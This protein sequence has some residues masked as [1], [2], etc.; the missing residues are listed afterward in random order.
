MDTGIVIEKE[1]DR[2]NGLSIFF[3]VRVRNR[4]N[5]TNKGKKQWG[6]F[7]SVVFSV[8]LKVRMVA[9]DRAKVSSQAKPSPDLNQETYFPGEGRIIHR[10]RSPE[11]RNERHKAIT[12]SPCHQI[13]GFSLMLPSCSLAVSLIAKMSRPSTVCPIEGI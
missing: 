10:Q 8:Q 2:G 13:W 11:N 9:S 1:G 12:Y 4:D 3:K 5:R 6:Q 7:K